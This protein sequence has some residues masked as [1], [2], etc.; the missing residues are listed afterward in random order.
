M[1]KVLLIDNNED[2]LEVFE[3]T[4]VDEG[5]NVSTANNGLN[6]VERFYK[7]RFDL[8]ITGTGMPGMT[9]F[10]LINEI[11][12]SCDVPVMLM[13]SDYLPAGPDDIKDLGINAIISKTIDNE[14]L[15]N[16]A[17]NCILENKIY[18]GKIF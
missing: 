4:L 11:N 9:G 5:F 14:T 15:C 17:R 2:V 3:Q 16:V 6:G 7:D 18:P 13:S 1:K 10:E 12:N 8:V